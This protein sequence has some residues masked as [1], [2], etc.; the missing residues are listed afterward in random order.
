ML[1]WCYF[2]LGIS[3]KTVV[4]VQ[5][6]SLRNCRCEFA[7][8]ISLNFF[9]NASVGKGSLLRLESALYSCLYAVYI[10]CSLGCYTMAQLIGA[11]RYKPEGHVVG[12]CGII[13]IFY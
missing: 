5:S 13:R 2:F 11:L 7:F 9:C 1:Q 12:S 3:V 6:T 10:F 4:A 8:F